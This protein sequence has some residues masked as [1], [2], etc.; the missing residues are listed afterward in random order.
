MASVDPDLE[1]VAL[2]IDELR[3]LPFE[4]REARIAE[5]PEEDRIAVW[6]FELEVAEDAEPEDDDELGGG[7]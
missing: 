7:D 6:E 2:L 3:D 1:R 4:E 5:L